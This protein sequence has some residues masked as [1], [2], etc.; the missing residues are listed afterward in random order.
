MTDRLR[1]AAAEIVS[2]LWLHCDAIGEVGTNCA[3]VCLLHHKGNIQR[4]HGENGQEAGVNDFALCCTGE[5]TG[6]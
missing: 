5:E 6:C 2:I 1:S 4:A 3:S